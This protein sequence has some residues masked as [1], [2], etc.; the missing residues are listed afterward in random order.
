MIS[1]NNGAGAV[2]GRPLTREVDM[3]ASGY[4]RPDMVQR[5][6]ILRETL[7]RFAT[8]V[9]SNIFHKIAADNLA[10]WRA[11]AVAA[12]PKGEVRVFSGDWGDVTRDL[13]KEHGVCFAALNM[14]NAYVPGG[15]Y[16]EGMVAQE[17]NMFR[18][19]DCHF[20]VGPDEYDEAR[21]RY[22]PD[23]TRLLSAVDGRV[24][25]DNERPRVCLRGS[26]DRTRSDLGYA[27]LSRD[28]IF[29]FFELRASAQDL[30]NG[31]PF[32]PLEARRRIAAQLDT[33]RDADIRYAVLGAFGCGAFRNPSIEVARL[34]REEIDRRRGDFALIAF[35]IFSAGYGPGNYAPFAAELG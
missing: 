27:W 35:A 22:T 29:P 1:I 20:C 16:V 11:E 17:E 28:Q 12:K 8:A 5:R 3:I 10:H 14:A 9:P 13:T 7:D 19:T 21:D 33:L 2:P 26:E 23:M 24:Y 18:R 30:R 6:A 4:G 32:D 34:Y 25:L 31:S 15:G